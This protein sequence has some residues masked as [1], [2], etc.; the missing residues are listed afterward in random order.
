MTIARLLRILSRK[1]RAWYIDVTALARMSPQKPVARYGGRLSG[2]KAAFVFA[3]AMARLEAGVKSQMPPTSPLHRFLRVGKECLVGR[4][5]RAVYYDMR[6]RRGCIS[7]HSLARDILV[8]GCGGSGTTYVTSLLRYNG[9]AVTHDTHLGRDGLVTNAC[10]GREVW[11]YAWNRHGIRAYVLL[12]VPVQ[13]FKHV[14]HLVRHPLKAIGS[15]YQKWQDYGQMWPHVKSAMFTDDHVGQVSLHH[16]C[17][18]WLVWN[19]NIERIAHARFRVEDL[20]VSPVH[21]FDAVQRPYRRTYAPKQE[22]GASGTKWYPTW[23][24]I[25]SADP[26]TCRRIRQLAASYGYLNET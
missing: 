12:K 24:D 20:A 15:V 9:V 5:P 8:T 2:S 23:R 22:V 13:E 25:E 26:E 21:L 7:G 19:Q 10:D 11:I 1:F 18:Y 16:V 6:A 4:G 14:V 3:K 17:K